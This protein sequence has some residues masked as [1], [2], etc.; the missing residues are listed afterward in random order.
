MLDLD[1]FK[2]INDTFGHAAGDLALTAVAGLVRTRLRT[3]DLFCRFGGE[4]FV[5]LLPGTDQDGAVHL[6][7]S[8]RAGLARLELEMEGVCFTLTGSFG[9]AA[10]L[11]SDA[12]MEQPLARADQAMYRAKEEGRDRVR[13]APLPENWA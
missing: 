12:S 9:V 7:E 3:P 5:L 1:H 2:S 10:V 11:A 4:E 8:L 6:A 13:Q